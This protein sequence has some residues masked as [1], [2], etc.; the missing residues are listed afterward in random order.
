[1]DTN[2]KLT[3]LFDRIVLEMAS[4]PDK[5][6]KI[7]VPDKFKLPPNEGI[8]LAVGPGRYEAGALVPMTVKVGDHVLVQEMRGI[9]FKAGSKMLRIV[10]EG[11]IM[12]II[13]RSSLVAV[14]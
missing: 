8:V 2:T 5:K 13:E 9:D 3:P 1:M 11:A 12:A 7:I 4:E 6:S 10:E 14:S